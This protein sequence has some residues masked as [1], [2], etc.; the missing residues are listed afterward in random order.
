MSERL[1]RIEA[2]LEQV[3]QQ[4]A[5]NTLAIAAIQQGVDTRFDGIWKVCESNAKSIAALSQ[6]V[7][8][9]RLVADSNARS[10]QGLGQTLE[11]DRAD[12]EEE[13]SQI[14]LDLNLLSRGVDGL[15]RERRNDWHEWRQQQSEQQSEWNLRIETLLQDARADRQVNEQ[16]HRAFRET[17]QTLLAEIARIWQQLR[18]A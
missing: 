16:E 6:E 3:A 8:E 9:T 2:L 12:R 10:I 17:F 15:I 18:S 13:D 7:A 5:S 11:D 14:R 4:Q 1:D